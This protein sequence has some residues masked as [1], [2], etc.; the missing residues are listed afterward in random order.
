MPEDIFDTF[1]ELW[2]QARLHVALASY[3]HR[4]CCMG[5]ELL[6]SPQLYSL[7]ICV[8]G[9]GRRDYR[10]LTN[11]V[12]QG[13][14]LRVLKFRQLYH[15]R[16]MGQTTGLGTTFPAEVVRGS[17]RA[18]LW[19]DSSDKQLPSL[20][21][22]RIHKSFTYDLDSA[23]CTDWKQKVDWKGLKRLDIDRFIPTELL[24][25][26]TGEVL[27]LKNFSYGLYLTNSRRTQRDHEATLKAFFAEINGLERFCIRNNNTIEIFNSVWPSI[28]KHHGPTLLNL[29]APFETGYG[30]I[31]WNREQIADLVHHAPGLKHLNIDLAL[32]VRQPQ[33]AARLVIF[34]F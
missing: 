15:K 23:Y 14:G 16:K 3:D 25:V 30:S 17:V 34:P 4:N 2:P 27:N 11:I 12:T 18:C 9:Y 22:L 1:H 24:A 29:R 10:K 21:E 26:L 13:P 8:P 7:V 28:L 32:H 20:E 33:T 5:N 6:L 31:G 19:L